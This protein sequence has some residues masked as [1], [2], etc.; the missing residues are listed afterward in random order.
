MSLSLLISCL[1]SF[2]GDGKSIL[3]SK[4]ITDEK[5]KANKIILIA[6]HNRVL[7]KKADYT[8]SLDNGNIKRLND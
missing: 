6:T 2:L 1:I 8:L 7:A 3:S 4:N 5:I